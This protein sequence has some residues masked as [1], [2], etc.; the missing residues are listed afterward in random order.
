MEINHLHGW[1]VTSKEAVQIQ[2][3]LASTVIHDTPLDIA[4]VKYLAGVDVSVKNNISQA[5]VVVL[6]Y[7]ELHVVESVTA[8]QPTPFP[9]ISGLLTFR[10]GP[11]LEEAFGQLQQEP[12]VFVF[13][14]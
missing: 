4:A 2:K 7:P 1:N 12:D 5:A 13:D 3:D 6:T 14:G 8:S 9:Y 10:E 11:V